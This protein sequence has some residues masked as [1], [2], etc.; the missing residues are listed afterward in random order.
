MP[1]PPPPIQPRNDQ[2]H[3]DVKAL[4]HYFAPLFL[5]TKRS[6]VQNLPVQLASVIEDTV[7]SVHLTGMARQYNGQTGYQA[8]DKL[9]VKDFTD[10]I[11]NIRFLDSASHELMQDAGIFYQRFKENESK[12]MAGTLTDILVLDGGVIKRLPFTGI[13]SDKFNI[14][15]MCDSAFFETLKWALDKRYSDQSSWAGHAHP[16]FIECKKTFLKKYPDCTK[17]EKLGQLYVFLKTADKKSLNEIGINTEIGIFE[18]RQKEIKNGPK[19][20][21]DFSIK[22]TCVNMFID[23]VNILNAQFDGVEKYEQ[24]NRQLHENMLIPLPVITAREL[25]YW[26]NPSKFPI[27][28]L[29]WYLFTFSKNTFMGKLAQIDEHPSSAR[30]LKRSQGSEYTYDMFTPPA[31]YPDYLVWKLL[32]ND[33]IEELE[34]LFRDHEEGMKAALYRE[35]EDVFEFVYE[36]DLGD[37]E[38]PMLK[39]LVKWG[40]YFDQAHK[41][42]LLQDA[43]SEND[44]GFLSYLLQT[45]IIEDLFSYIPNRGITPLHLILIEGSDEM[46][47]FVNL[48]FSLTNPSQE[49]KYVPIYRETSFGP[50]YWKPQRNNINPKNFIYANGLSIRKNWDYLT[51]AAARGKFDLARRLI[52]MGAPTDRYERLKPFMINQS[53]I[54]VY[55]KHKRAAIVT[56]DAKK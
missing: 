44:I 36:S 7:I 18:N 48:N 38:R 5:V 39:R 28:R 4:L 30:G 20:E 51:L 41:K 46:I 17:N 25:D 56:Q 45:G 1:P 35:R 24:I 32:K 50:S 13:P 47:D 6:S 37:L 19:A 2:M 14:M 9:S 34:N 23:H 31:K 43:V 54:N 42:A 52:E 49:I 53:H 3:I 16:K 21:F 26:I 22:G 12:I 33:K 10:S 29:F 8:K 15:K 27:V 55:M 40:F 11:E